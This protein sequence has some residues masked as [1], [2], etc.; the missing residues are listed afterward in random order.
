MWSERAWFPLY[1]GFSS[2]EEFLSCSA[3]LL[4]QEGKYQT[5]AYLFS[6]TFP[7]SKMSLQPGQPTSQQGFHVRP[8]SKILLILLLSFALTI[9]ENLP[10]CLT[11]IV[12]YCRRLKAWRTQDP[13]DHCPSLV[14]TCC[15]VKPSKARLGC[16][17]KGSVKKNQLHTYSSLSGL[18]VKT[19]TV[20]ILW[21]S[22][23]WQCCHASAIGK[24]RA[25]LPSF[26][27]SP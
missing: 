17:N 26:T 20:L 8:I 21:G 1:S 3:S 2:P 12:M 4:H 10:I 15:E 25:T 23:A 14:S 6:K 24:W 9:A 22:P 13:L 16:Q 18:Q 19:F 27:D 5:T 11:G 7:I